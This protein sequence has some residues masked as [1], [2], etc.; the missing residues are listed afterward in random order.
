MVN[1]ALV[2]GLAIVASFLLGLVFAAQRRDG[3]VSLQALLHEPPA[4]PP[5][6][7]A[8]ALRT[9]GARSLRRP[10]VLFLT[11]FYT[12]LAVLLGFAIGM[13]VLKNVLPG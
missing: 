8:R 5:K 3:R 12:L 10:D 11:V 7:I 13:A 4:I 2:W 6:Y 9:E 1:G